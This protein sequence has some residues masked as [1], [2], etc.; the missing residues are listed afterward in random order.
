MLSHSLTMSHRLVQVSLK[1]NAEVIAH[2]RAAYSNAL[3]GS[4]RDMVMTQCVSPAAAELGLWPWTAALQ[5]QPGVTPS[6]FAAA[7]CQ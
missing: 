4:C 3:N 6:C 2:A 1:A 7:A 5:L